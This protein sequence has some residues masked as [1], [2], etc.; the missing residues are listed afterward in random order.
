VKVDTQSL[1]E[2][3]ERRSTEE[4]IAILRNHDEGEW[5]A[6]V[7]DVV[8]SVLKARGVSPD[9]I[10]ALGPEGY[11]VAESE[12]TETVAHFFSPA[13]A[14]ASRMA[15]EEAGL[16]AWVADEAVGTMYG[17][18]VGTRLQVRTKDVEAARE[19][20][21]SASASADALPPDLAEPPCPVC[22]SRNVTPEAWPDELG[23]KRPGWPGPR[24]KWYYVCGDCREAWPL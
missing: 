2:R 24:R 10:I 17:V 18:G 20:L 7:F 3:F 8:A 4:L 22:G 13:E 14:H 11:A 6:E 19:V 23:A 12:P 5:R 21:S 16:A 9:E 15:L 1:L